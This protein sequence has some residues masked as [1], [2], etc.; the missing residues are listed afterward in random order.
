[1]TENER[2]QL[3]FGPITRS[4]DFGYLVRRVANSP[5]HRESPASWIECTI[6]AGLEIPER[7]RGDRA[8]RGIIRASVAD[9]FE[10]GEGRRRGEAAIVS[11]SGEKALMPIKQGIEGP[12]HGQ[13]PSVVASGARKPSFAVELIRLLVG[14]DRRAAC[15]HVDT[16]P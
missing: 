6:T 12:D 11:E 7:E 3:R 1:M 10:F 13:A 4:R 2:N 16:P 15:H 14:E 5:G 9:Y 8:L